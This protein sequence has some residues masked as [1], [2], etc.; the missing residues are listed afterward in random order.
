MT[1]YRHLL[2]SKILYHLFVL[3][4]KFSISESVSFCGEEELST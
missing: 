4:A 2:P 3:F 1:R